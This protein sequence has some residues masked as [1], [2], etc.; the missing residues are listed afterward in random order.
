[1]SKQS[2][3]N[4]VSK[5]VGRIRN[6]GQRAMKL[7]YERAAEAICILD[8]FKRNVVANGGTSDR[9]SFLGY[10]PGRCRALR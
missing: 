2:D 1:M 5:Q 9:L 6:W 8:R 4:V 10:R 3:L 7:D